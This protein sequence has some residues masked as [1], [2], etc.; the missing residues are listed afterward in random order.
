MKALTQTQRWAIERLVDHFRDKWVGTRETRINPNTLSSLA[1]RGLVAITWTPAPRRLIVR[2]TDAGVEYVQ[3][4][5]K[6]HK[7]RVAMDGIR[8]ERER[9]AR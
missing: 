1:D 8:K 7:R 2:V 4:Y 9:R 6:W 5:Q 3:Q